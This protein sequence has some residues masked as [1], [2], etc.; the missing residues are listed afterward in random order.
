MHMV[1]RRS[2]IRQHG[3]PGSLQVVV[4]VDDPARDVQRVP[5][6]YLEGGDVHEGL[7]IIDELEEDED[8]AVRQQGA[9]QVRE[10]VPLAPGPA[11][12]SFF[13]GEVAVVVEVVVGIGEVLDNV[14]QVEG[15]LLVMD[16][17]EFGRFYLL[18]QT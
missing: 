16:R 3:A 10:V 9:V 2:R 14:A 13:L 5:D 18:N 8:A 12:P 6:R 17:D 7:L 1:D 11:G 4:G 15:D